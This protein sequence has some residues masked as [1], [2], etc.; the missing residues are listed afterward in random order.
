MVSAAMLEGKRPKKVTITT[1]PDQRKISM[2][3]IRTGCGPVIGRSQ[4]EQ[5][6]QQH[7][8][9]WYLEGLEGFRLPDLA[10]SVAELV[11][12]SVSVRA[13]VVGVA[14]KEMEEE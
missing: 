4:G 1:R 14:A 13:D 8:R 10:A 12:A 3:R 7:R 9:D 11:R 6:Q 2:Q 5:V